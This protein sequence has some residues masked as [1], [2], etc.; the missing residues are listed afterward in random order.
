MFTVSPDHLPFDIEC[1][2][3]EQLREACT[4]CTELAPTIDCTAAPSEI[5]IPD[6]ALLDAQ[7]TANDPVAI[8]KNGV[9]YYS[10]DEALKLLLPNLTTV[11]LDQSEVYR[12]QMAAICTAALGWYN[13]N[14]ISEEYKTPA[15]KDVLELRKKYWTALDEIKSLKEAN[16]TFARDAIK[17]DEAS[18]LEELASHIEFTDSQAAHREVEELRSR[19]L[20]LTKEYAELHEGSQHAIQICAELQKLAEA[21]GWVYTPSGFSPVGQI[22]DWLD[23]FVKVSNEQT[24]LNQLN[25][26]ANTTVDHLRHQLNGAQ[27]RINGLVAAEAGARADQIT[28]E[29]AYEKLEKKYKSAQRKIARLTGR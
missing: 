6:W 11:E 23:T 26:E 25:I 18:P 17:S 3:I 13:G 10:P 22:R 4:V 7:C 14:A 9:N 29:Q 24:K 8:C 27:A 12:I 21:H 19:V 1:E 28:I 16:N 20:K 2:T 15:L 5:K